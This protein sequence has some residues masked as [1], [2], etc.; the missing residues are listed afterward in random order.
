MKDFIQ[1]YNPENRHRG[2]GTERFKG[3]TY[4]EVLKR[5]KVNLDIFWLRDA[6]LEDSENLPTPNIIAQ[7]IVENL[8]SA[9]EEFSQIEDE[10]ISTK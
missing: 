9:L 4:D 3:F 6:S 5:D 10:L 8:E 7:E 2:K 1:C